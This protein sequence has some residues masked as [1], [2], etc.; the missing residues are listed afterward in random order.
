MFPANIW[1]IAGLPIPATRFLAQTSSN[2]IC[3]ESF[4]GRVAVQNGIKWK[5]DAINNLEALKGLSPE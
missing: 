2:A 3:C 1:A 5:C 4:E